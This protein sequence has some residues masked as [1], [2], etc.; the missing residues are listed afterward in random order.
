MALALADNE[1]TYWTV[2]LVLG[3]VVI[4][5]VVALLSVLVHYVKVIDARVLRVRNTLERISH[6]TEHV[7]LIP[8]TADNVDTVLAEGLRHHLFLGRAASATAPST[9]EGQS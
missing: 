8:R 4:L 7:T 5:A 6:N 1:I 3:L 2:I 9:K